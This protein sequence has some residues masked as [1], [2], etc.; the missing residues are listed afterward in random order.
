MSKVILFVIAA[1][2]CAAQAWAGDV[3]VTDAW[4][5]A[6][7]PGQ[8]SV[9][10]SM[11]IV[12]QKE[13][14]LI[15]VI[16][17]L[18]DTAEIHLMKHEG[19]KMNMQQVDALPLPA[20]QEVVL[21]SGSH[22]MLTGLKHELKEGDSVPLKLTIEFANKKREIVEVKAEVRSLTSGH[23]MHDMHHDMHGM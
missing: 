23:Q 22:L 11:H 17:P 6:T 12:S 14:R 16:S 15:T 21:G 20:K 7:A 8:D 9:A 3:A 13:A 1:L 18:A 10:V 4:I 2:F 5:R 19:G